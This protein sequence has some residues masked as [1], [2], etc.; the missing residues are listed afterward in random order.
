VSI[1]CD[2]YL[3]LEGPQNSDNVEHILVQAD[4][5]VSLLLPNILQVGFSNAGSEAQRRLLVHL[6][7]FRRS[8][9]TSDPDIH[10]FY[11]CLSPAPHPPSNDIDEGLQPYA[12]LP[13][14][15]PFQRRSTLKLLEFEKSGLDMDGKRTSVDHAEVDIGIVQAVSIPP[16][17]VRL[18]NEHQTITTLY[19]NR[20]SGAIS[21]E[22]PRPIG[23]GYG[24]ILAEEMGLGLFTVLLVFIANL[25]YRRKNAGMYCPHPPQSTSYTEPFYNTMVRRRCFR[26]CDH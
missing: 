6:E 3:S 1:Q 7:P 8:N 23:L 11:A 22:K 26:S 14:L 4:F 15:L 12:L 2:L 13:T 18:N 16:L 5:K 24:G 9:E 10:S 20:L 25:Y 17:R 19:F 21:A